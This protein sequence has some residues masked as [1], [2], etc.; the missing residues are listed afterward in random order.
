VILRL[1]FG[2]KVLPPKTPRLVPWGAGSVLLVVVGWMISTASISQVYV[3]ALRPVAAEGVQAARKM[4]NPGELMAL[5][6]VQNTATLVLIPLILAATCGARPRD[7]G[8]VASGFGTQFFRGMVAYPLLAPLVFGVMGLSVLVWG[9]TPHPVEDAIAQNS[10]P[11]LVAL[12]VLAAILLAPA[13]EELI[14]RGVLLGWLTRLSLGGEKRK[15]W[16]EEELDLSVSSTIVDG[17]EPDDLLI[18]D[19]PD[20]SNDGETWDDPGPLA[21]SPA[22]ASVLVQPLAQEPAPVPSRT[23]PL[24]LSNVV[25]SLVFAALHGAV[26]PTPIPIFFLSLGLGFLY[27]RTGSLIPS[28]A[29]HMTFNGVSTLLMFLTLGG[30]PAEKVEPKPTNPVPP[31]ACS[32]WK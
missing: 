6:S 22:P 24:L 10:S 30:K 12:S 5:V 1:A 8:L 29:M 2:L 16:V 32:T 7:L 28:V 21:A 20:T 31:P 19:E 3:R 15:P 4:M 25:V 9:R 14:F 18:A 23:L 11:G 27:Q 13:A 26:W 17:Q